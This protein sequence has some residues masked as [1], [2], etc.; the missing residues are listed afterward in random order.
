MPAVSVIIPVYNT[1]PYLCRC[2]DSVTG[3]TLRDIEIICVNDGSTD[4]SLEILRGYEQKDRRLKVIDF[5]ENRG[6]SAARNAGME[7]ALGEYIGFVDSDDYVELDFYEKLYQKAIETGADIAKG[8]IRRE[9]IILDDNTNIKKDKM[10]FYYYFTSA[11]Y[12][13]IFLKANGI[14]FPEGLA[15]EED[16]VFTIY[17]AAAAQR[18]SF[19]DDAWYEY[20][21]RPN[22]AT[23]AP[24]SSDKV[25]SMMAASN[26]ISEMLAHA[27]L[28]SSSYLIL[29]KIYLFK[30]IPDYLRKCKNEEGRLCILSG[31]ESLWRDCKHKA[32][33]ATDTDEMWGKFCRYMDKGNVKEAINV[34]ESEDIAKNIAAKLRRRIEIQ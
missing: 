3:Q 14:C 18:I 31:L 21:K 34:L 10:Y 12:N 4:N 29:Y 17:A 15:Y 26:L 6:V 23:E 5:A 20:V 8:R 1:S 28:T 27:K 30:N 16:P 32:L 33:L 13:R 2:L 22:S 11:V 25:Y 7:A 24:F 19:N 9:N